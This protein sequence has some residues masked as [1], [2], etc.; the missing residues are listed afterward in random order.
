MEGLGVWLPEQRI[1]TQTSYPEPRAGWGW[2]RNNEEIKSQN[3]AAETVEGI[4]QFNP[5]GG[6]KAGRGMAAIL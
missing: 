2:R 3:W 1:R 4:K 6:L 5:S